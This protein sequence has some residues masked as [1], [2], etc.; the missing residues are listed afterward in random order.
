MVGYAMNEDASSLRDRKTIG[1]TILLVENEEPVR[2]FAEKLLRDWG[3][4]VRA[5]R[6]G[7]EA[8]K[9]WQQSA[10]EIDLLLTDIVLPKSPSGLD[11]AERFLQTRPALKIL[12]TS[13]Y[14]IE[15]LEHHFG[16][17]P[18]GEFLAKP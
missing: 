13:G 9:I 4:E 1:K 10:E 3:Y 7:D 12:Y 11:L 6:D 18:A 16:R 2:R 5:A 17:R 8:L 14:N 15:L